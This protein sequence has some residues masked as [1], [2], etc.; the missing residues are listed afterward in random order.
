M[1]PMNVPLQGL[2]KLVKRGG[3]PVV[4]QFELQFIDV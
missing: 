4:S 2:K 3:N 1:I